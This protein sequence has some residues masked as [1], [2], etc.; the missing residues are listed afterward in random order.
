[1]SD[2]TITWTQDRFGITAKIVCAAGLDAVCHQSCPFGCEEWGP[3]HEHALAD[4]GT[5]L[6]VEW[7]EA[8][9]GGAL[10]ET[11]PHGVRLAPHDGAVTVQYTDSAWGWEYADQPSTPGATA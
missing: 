5:C 8:T 9:S 3:N 4:Y 11:G 7:M 1:V 10:W 6:A 2:H